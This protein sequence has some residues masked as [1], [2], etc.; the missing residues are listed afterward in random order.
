[1]RG[2]LKGVRAFLARRRARRLA[3]VRE[4]ALLLFPWLLIGAG[5]ALGLV[6]FASSVHLLD[7]LEVAGT[8]PANTTASVDVD[9][10]GSTYSEVFLRG[11]P[12]C[13][14]AVYVLDPGEAAAFLETQGLPSDYLGCRQTHA[15]YGAGIALL[16]FENPS[17]APVPYDLRVEFVGI[18]QPNALW[19]LPAS[20]LLAGGGM[21]EIRRMLQGGLIRIVDEFSEGET[22]RP[23]IDRDRP[24]R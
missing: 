20:V 15:V 19:I 17:D 18:T 2:A 11:A 4:R 5:V 21:I 24:R 9:S 1:M 13:A 7:A 3:T 14:L 23:P 22:L 6:S 16:V 8:V 12:T 10:N